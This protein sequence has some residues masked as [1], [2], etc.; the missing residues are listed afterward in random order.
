MG[1]GPVCVTLKIYN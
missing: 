1:C